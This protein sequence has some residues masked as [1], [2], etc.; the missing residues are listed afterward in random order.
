MSDDDVKEAVRKRD[1][2]K[3][4]NCGCT[5]ED[6]LLLME[7]QLQVHRVIPGSAYTMKGCLTLCQHCHAKAHRLDVSETVEEA[8][9]DRRKELLKALEPYQAEAQALWEN[10][11][12]LAEELRTEEGRRKHAKLWARLSPRMRL[13]LSGS[14]GK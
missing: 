3:C 5:Q 12:R 14:N 7:Q 9:G 10:G 6:H 13:R 1:G 2:Y 4:P 8:E 11:R